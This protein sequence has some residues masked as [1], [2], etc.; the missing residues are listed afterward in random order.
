MG[1]KVCVQSLVSL[2]LQALRWNAVCDGLGEND[3]FWWILLNHITNDLNDG[4]PADSNA[5]AFA[6]VLMERVNDTWTHSSYCEDMGVSVVSEDT[7]LGLLVRN[8]QDDESTLKVISVVNART[9]CSVLTIPSPGQPVVK[10]SK[11]KTLHLD[12]SEIIRDCPIT[13]APWDQRERGWFMVLDVEIQ[14][15]GGVKAEK[16]KVSPHE[17]RFPN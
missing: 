6:L 7:V 4:L 1:L 13:Y 16:F 17:E 5:P 8:R 11:K 12:L 14:N 10:V 15:D 2:R 3:I 9:S